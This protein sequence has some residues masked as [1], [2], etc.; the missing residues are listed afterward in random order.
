MVGL[1]RELEIIIM[2]DEDCF[3]EEFF[4]IEFEVE[5]VKKKIIKREDDFI[6]GKLLKFL[7]EENLCLKNVLR[8]LVSMFKVGY[9]RII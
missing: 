9:G 2:V 4:F 3:D 6:G 8:S 7:K 5:K 1:K